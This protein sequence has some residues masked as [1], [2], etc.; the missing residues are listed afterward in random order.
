M[1]FTDTPW[2]DSCALGDAFSAHIIFTAQSAGVTVCPNV[3]AADSTNIDA[4]RDTSVLITSLT[5]D[6]K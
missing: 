4:K 1:L 3:I 6:I 2:L 5:L